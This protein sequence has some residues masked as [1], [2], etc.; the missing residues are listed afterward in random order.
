MNQSARIAIALSVVITVLALFVH[1]YIDGPDSVLRSHHQNRVLVG[2]LAFGLAQFSSLTVLHA[3]V[4][5][6]VGA[7]PAGPDLFDLLCTRLC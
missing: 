4:P 5:E 2:P 6:S 7:E 3:S 1:P